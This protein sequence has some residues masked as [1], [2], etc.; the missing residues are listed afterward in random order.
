[1]PRIS[2]LA[3]FLLFVLAGSDAFSQKMVQFKVEGPELLTTDRLKTF[4]IQTEVPKIKEIAN[5]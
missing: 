1:M 5:L 2:P 4:L 3:L